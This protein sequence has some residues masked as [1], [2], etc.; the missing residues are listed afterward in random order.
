MKALPLLVLLASMTACVGDV[1]LVVKGVI[2]EQQAS[3]ML[4]VSQRGQVISD[5]KVSGNFY[6]AY[7]V[8]RP[9]SEIEASVV[10]NEAKVAVRAADEKGSEIDFGSIYLK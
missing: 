9:L 8:R 6:E 7:A 3:C 2:H 5:L 1:Q 4:I 10:C